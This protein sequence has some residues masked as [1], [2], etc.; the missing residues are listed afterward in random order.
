MCSLPAGV[1]LP[2]IVNLIPKSTGNLSCLVTSTA[3]AQIKR[4][5]MAEFGKSVGGGRREDKR[6]PSPLSVLLT[7]LAKSHDAELVDISATGARVRGL[8][9]PHVGEELNLAAGRV[10]TFCTVRWR[11]D[12][13]CGVQFYE[14]LLQAE[15]IGVRRE[16]RDGAGIAPAF[17][18]AFDDWVLGVAR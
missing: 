5:V 9:L 10:K 6:E 18:A 15:V 1:A 8:S 7:G 4:S 11:R 3:G 16:V 14:P 2:V 12:D 13:E 17:R